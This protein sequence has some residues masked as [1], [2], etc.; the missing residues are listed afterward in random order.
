MTIN[1]NT[2]LEFSLQQ[3]T[4]KGGVYTNFYTEDKGSASIRIRLSSDGN[5]LDLTKTDLKPVLFLFH[6][7]GSIFEVRDFINVMP[8]KGLIQYNLSDNVIRHAGKVKAKVF[9][10]SDTKSVHVANFTFD[11]KDSGIEGTVGKE[12]HL[13]ILD[14][15]VKKVILDN[16][17]LFKGKDANPEDVKKLL[18]PYAD[19]KA[20]QEFEKLSAAKQQD[21]EV[22]QARSGMSS[23]G[24]RLDEADKK[25]NNTQRVINVKSLGAK[26][27]G[28]TDDYQ[29][30]QDAIYEAERTNSNVYIPSGTYYV[31]Q[32][33]RTAHKTT[34]H[35][36]TGIRIFGDGKTSVL[37]GN[38]ANAVDYSD[39]TK[40]SKGALIA[41]HG[42]NNI[43]EN[44]EL[45]QC[46]VGIFFGQHPDVSDSY[47]SVSF[48]TIEN[49]W[50][51]F[52]GTGILMIH[53]LGNNYNRFKKIH[54]LNCQ[55]GVHLGKGV[56]W[57]Q[58]NNNRNVFDTIRVSYAWIGYL[59]E[60]ADGNAFNS[61]YGENMTANGEAVGDQPVQLPTSLNGKRT[62]VVVLDGQYNFFDKTGV[63]NC[64][65][66]LYSTGFRTTFD[67]MM[68]RDDA[69]SRS[70]VSFP[71]S[72][73]MPQY[74]HSDSIIMPH[75]I[76]QPD[77]GQYFDN[78]NGMGI[79]SRLF[80][81]DYHWQNMK[82][83]TLTSDMASVAK[84]S[85]SKIRRLG[86][87]VTWQA[88][89]R[90]EKD[91]SVNKTSPIKIKIPFEGKLKT[92]ESL[93]TNEVSYATTMSFP[94]FVGVSGKLEHGIARFSTKSETSAYGAQHL[95]I[96]PPSNGWA[97]T[98]QLNNLIFTLNWYNE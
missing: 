21:A 87:L 1:K 70:L 23:L 98:S 12:I 16:Q 95:I 52:V 42:G 26:G 56:Q 22:I 89:Y 88:N 83:E 57:D 60:Q 94:I 6:E 40:T 10:K 78:S 38:G 5:Y 97:E 79:K 75:Y 91:S 17:E 48:N 80:D 69:K 25:I 20:K 64:Q 72:T 66:H 35:Y 24:S 37:K 8:D 63:E 81:I 33:L 92:L 55:I 68:V 74:Y 61:L 77:A 27:N 28:K 50:M 13:D 84:S 4:E 58:Y 49:I 62:A 11:I 96:N 67:N 29:I 30:I 32:T 86:G 14:D 7:D 45:T 46:T 47:S 51:E 18:E 39:L 59:I 43:V 93:Y 73:R 19:K 41:L 54:V 85:G 76:Y 44:L 31:S 82:L 3:K 34:P 2:D 65:W 15:K 71:N 53:A 36:T 9:L 90:F